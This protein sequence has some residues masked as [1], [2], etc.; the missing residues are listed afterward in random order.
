MT[1]SPSFKIKKADLSEIFGSI[2]TGMSGQKFKDRAREGWGEP[3]LVWS[4]D[5]S[6]AAI[7]KN[8]RVIVHKGRYAYLKAKEKSLNRHFLISQDKD[9]ITV[10]TE[11]KNV[12]K[13]PHEKEV[14]WFKLIEIKVSKPFAAKGFI[15]AVTK[16]ISD[17]G[18]NVLVASTFSKDY[19]L[20]REETY[21]A[22][23]SALEE[24]GFKVNF[25]K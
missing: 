2:K 24:L 6:L 12:A 13:T 1:K 25:E 15:A 19:F 3:N 4:K 14:K 10:V 23:V 22:A 11:E 8:S 18:L 16:T 7:I 20:V 9:E 5:F 21:K 17:K